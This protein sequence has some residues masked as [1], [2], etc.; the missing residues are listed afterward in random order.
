MVH[1]PQNRH[2]P[3]T[4]VVGLFVARQQ[5]RICA[6]VWTPFLPYLITLLREIKQVL[7]VFQ[8]DLVP[9]V[10]R[11]FPGK[12]GLYMTLSRESDFREIN[13]SIKTEGLLYRRPKVVQ[14]AGGLLGD[15]EAAGLQQ[16]VL[17]LGV[18]NGSGVIA[19]NTDSVSVH[20]RWAASWTRSHGP[21]DFCEG[22]HD[23]VCGEGGVD[24]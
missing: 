6:G 18:R 5:Q 22:P 8:I 16:N 23:T 1:F 10:S 15:T 21:V 7:V 17:Q 13:W 4:S 14:Q 24:I 20:K 9:D 11:H 3:V 12:Q 2:G 19:K